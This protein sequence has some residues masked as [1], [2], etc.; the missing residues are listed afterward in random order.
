MVDTAATGGKKSV[1][2]KKEG[3]SGGGR[4]RIKG[5]S[6]LKKRKNNF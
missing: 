3:D 6:K 4:E 2:Q 1:K 5:P